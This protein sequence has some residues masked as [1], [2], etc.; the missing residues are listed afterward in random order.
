MGLISEE[1]QPKKETKLAP[2]F[3]VAA[4]LVAGSRFCF[5]SLSKKGSPALPLLGNTQIKLYQSVIYW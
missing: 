3:G 5:G 2:L 4:R 1:G